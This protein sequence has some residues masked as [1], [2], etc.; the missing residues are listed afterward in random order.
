MVLQAGLH[1]LEMANKQRD[2]LDFKNAGMLGYD[3]TGL[4]G[5]DYGTYI[6]HTA[7]GVT[8]TGRG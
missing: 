8:R 4:V 3:A 2:L 1:M 7:L 6:R 5:T